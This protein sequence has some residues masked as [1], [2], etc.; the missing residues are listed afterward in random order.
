MPHKENKSVITT[1]IENQ[2]KGQVMFNI[3]PQGW[4]S[5]IVIFE[6]LFIIHRTPLPSHSN[7]WNYHLSAAAICCSVFSAQQCRNSCS[8]WWSW[9]AEEPPQGNWVHRD[10]KSMHST[11]WPSALQW[12][13]PRTSEMAWDGPGL[14]LLQ[15]ELSGIPWECFASRCHVT[16]LWQTETTAIHMAY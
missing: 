6:C 10:L 14:P 16:P 11:T 9:E 7:M 12:R 3:F 2:H 4:I 15:T 1:V 5:D 8:L 13:L